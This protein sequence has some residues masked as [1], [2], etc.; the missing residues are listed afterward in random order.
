MDRH[1][2][3]LHKSVW[4]LGEVVR[5]CGPTV[6]QIETTLNTDMFP[7]PFDF[8]STSASGNG[9]R[10]TAPRTSATTKSLNRTPIRLARKIFHAIEGAAP[11]DLGAGR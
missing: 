4:R 2:S 8:M 11:D 5:D 9:S 3:E 1:K 10:R 7:S 6:F